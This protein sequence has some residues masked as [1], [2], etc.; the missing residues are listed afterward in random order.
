MIDLRRGLDYLET[1]GDIDTNRIAVYG[2]SQGG[3][4]SLIYAAI[5]NRCRLLIII[6]VGLP[7]A[8]LGW[9]AE[10]S[11]LNFAPHIRASKLVLNGRYDE[12]SPFKTDA[13]PLFKLLSEPKRLVLYDG[14]HTPPSEVAV[15]VINKWLD[16]N[17]GIP[18]S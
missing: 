12:A 3:E 5:E 17:L 18:K 1:R 10:A 9:I 8:S 13:E 4:S 14:S 7:K 16:E 11:P 15:P 2:Y 6:G